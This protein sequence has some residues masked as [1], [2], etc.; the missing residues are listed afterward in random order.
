MIKTSVLYLNNIDNQYFIKNN[1]PQP[2]H[3]W[4]MET[5]PPGILG[6]WLNDKRACLAQ[7]VF[8]LP[9]PHANFRR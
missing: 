5:L 8:I 2:I 6:T 9:L 4:P 7:Q 3:K 1:F